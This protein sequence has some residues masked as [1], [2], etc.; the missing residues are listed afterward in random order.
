MDEELFGDH[1]YADSAEIGFAGDECDTGI[2]EDIIFPSTTK[3]VI[4]KLK[5]LTGSSGTSAARVKEMVEVR[6]SKTI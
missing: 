3:V 5:T 4:V 6:L 2:H 1:L